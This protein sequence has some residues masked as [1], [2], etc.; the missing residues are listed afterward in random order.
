[1]KAPLRFVVLTMLL[2][3]KSNKCFDAVFM[4]VIFQMNS[5]HLLY[6]E[7]HEICYGKK[8][9]CHVIS[10]IVSVRDSDKGIC[11]IAMQLCSCHRLMYQ[12]FMQYLHTYGWLLIILCTSLTA[13]YAEVESV[14]TVYFHHLFEQH[15]STIVLHQLIISLKRVPV[16]C[17]LKL[18]KESNIY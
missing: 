11:K 15:R 4:F 14:R 9:L 13:F 8:E 1:M 7:N 18:F 3:R 17:M 5:C 6:V 2:I 10:I 16:V 12:H